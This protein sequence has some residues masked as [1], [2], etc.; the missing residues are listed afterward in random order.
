MPTILDL[1]TEQLGGGAISQMTRQLNTNRGQTEAAVSAVL[2]TLLG[3]MARNTTRQGGAQALLGALDRDHDGSIL[4]DVAGFLGQPDE[5]TGNGIL[6]HVLGEKRGTVEQG[7]SKASGLDPATVA[8]LMTMLA[9][10]VM[11]ALGKVKRERNLNAS[12][13]TNL[14]ESERTRV[15]RENPALSGLAQ[16]LD[17]DHDGQVGDDLAALGKKFLGGLFARQ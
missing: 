14:L 5:G 11:G 4:D 12:S 17:A 1:L 15:Q 7:V 3:A 9:P 8:K 13:L 16:L 10:L 2:P 6:R